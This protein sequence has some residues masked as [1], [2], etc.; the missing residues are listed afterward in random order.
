MATRITV[1]NINGGRLRH[2]VVPVRFTRAVSGGPDITAPDP[3]DRG[4]VMPIP[5]N[6]V[7]TTARGFSF[8]LTVGESAR[9]RVE[10]VDIDPSAPLAVRL[11]IGTPHQIQLTRPAGGGALPADGIIELRGIVDQAAQFGTKGTVIEVRLGSLEGPVLAEA[12]AHVLTPLTLNVAAHIHTLHPESGPPGSGTKPTH[13]G[14]PLDLDR[15]FEL[16]NAIYRPAG[17]RVRLAKR[18]ERENFDFNADDTPFLASRGRKGTEND[19]M[20]SFFVPNHCNVH[21]VRFMDGSGGV[22]IRRD[23]VGLDGIDQPGILSMMEGI[24]DFGTGRIVRLYLDPNLKFQL[25]AVLLAH[26][27]GHFLEL[28]HVTDKNVPGRVDTFSR[29]Q[30]MHPNTLVSA[31]PTNPRDRP[32]LPDAG[33]GNADSDIRQQIERVPLGGHLL[34]L[35]KYAVRPGDGEVAIARARAR[36]PNAVLY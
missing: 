15:L 30:I 1:Q 17:V 2:V 18:F 32:R 20:K 13:N 27:I 31:D 7:P 4:H 14:A 5:D 22:G 21:F 28:I 12:E 9:I 33:Y 8:G 10:R 26:E 35:K 19:V 6:W 34:T 3:D 11:R 29:R 16:V 25:L 24:R 36:Q 23:Q